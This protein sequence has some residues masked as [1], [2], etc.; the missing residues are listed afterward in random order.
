MRVGRRS[1]LAG[2]TALAVAGC[3]ELDLLS[4]VAPRGGLRTQRDLRYRPGPRGTLDLHRPAVPRPEAPL[5]VVFHGGGFGGGD[6]SQLLFLAEAL[7]RL[8]GPVAMPN[9][10]LVPEVRWPD[11]VEDAVAAV[12]W[13]LAGAGAGRQVVLLGYSAG[14]FLAAAL[15]I[16]P[17]WLGGQR[18]RL[19]GWVGL[20]GLYEIP[21]GSAFAGPAGGSGAV[22]PADPAAIVGAPPALLLHGGTDRVVPPD[23]ARRL[24]ARLRAAGVPARVVVEPERGHLGVMASLAFPVRMLG[25]LP[26]TTAGEEL[27]GF[28]ASPAA[29]AGAAG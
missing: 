8:G 21:P 6:K 26:G 28:V 17:R 25:L 1:L 19:S 9:Y 5:L 14:A 10:R 29:W 22:L 27:A 11:F 3:S 4:L 12:T 15:A 24:G 13:L 23:Q 16:D 18:A 7:V 20:S 2:G